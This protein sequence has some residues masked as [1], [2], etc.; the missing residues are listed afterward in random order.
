MTW[1]LR[2]VAGVAA[3]A[4]AAAGAGCA[5]IGHRPLREVVWQGDVT[6][7]GTLVVAAGERLVIRPGTRVVFAFRDEDGDGVGD[8]RLVIRGAIDASGSETAPIEFAPETA[9]APGAPRWA[10]VLVEDAVSARF[11]HC[12]FVGAQ[13]AVHAH[14]TPLVVASCRFERNGI[15][16]RFTGGPVAI[17]GSRFAANATA[18]RYWESSP[19]IV[20]NVFEGNATA[21]FV[22]EGSQRS[23]VTGNNFMSS[24]DYHVKLGELQS[25]DVDARGNW[26]GTDQREQIERL[27]YDRLDADYLGRVRYDPPASGPLGLAAP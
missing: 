12:R 7:R 24:A 23:V 17:R 4:L 22:R 21:V 26:W 8:A 5:H 2:G 3:C 10:E 15:G 13:Q 16:L 25:A 20:G 27:I 18:V 9:G 6:V 1:R 11:A 14:R 19:E